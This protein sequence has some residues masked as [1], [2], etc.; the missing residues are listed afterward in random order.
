[1]KANTRSIS[2]HLPDRGAADKLIQIWIDKELHKKCQTKRKKLH[3][4]WRDIVIAGFRSFV[5][6]ED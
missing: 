3:L 5:E 1:M 6:V 2:E 4:T